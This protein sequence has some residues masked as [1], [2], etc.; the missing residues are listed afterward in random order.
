LSLRAIGI[1]LSPEESALLDRILELRRKVVAHS[2][3]DEMHFVA[4]SFLVADDTVRFP[5]VQFEERLEFE[6]N[7]VLS[8]EALLRK[9][10][11]GVGKLIFDVAQ[12]EPE[13]LE[14]RRVPARLGK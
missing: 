6:R 1:A 7:E 9:L 4:S 13:R 8:I 12:H 3:E 5:Q 14:A 11:A 10:I 2:D